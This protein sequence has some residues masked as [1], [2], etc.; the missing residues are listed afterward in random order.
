MLRLAG[1][2]GGP[3]RLSLSHSV[4]QAL[5]PFVSVSS[6]CAEKAK[7]A[8]T[9]TPLGI[10]YEK[11]TVGVPKETFDLERRV[12]AT[13]ESVARLVKSGFQAVHVETGAGAKSF[14]SDQAYEQAGAKIVD[15]AWKDSNIVLKVCITLCVV[16][17]MGARLR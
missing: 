4:R 9:A 10:P 5:R 16:D 17:T 7:D 6:I 8:A 11:L 2:R 15:N 14:F 12:A 3:G 13:P 1:V